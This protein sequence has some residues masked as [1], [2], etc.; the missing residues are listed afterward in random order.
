MASSRA[1]DLLKRVL[2][3]VFGG[4]TFWGASP[5]PAFGAHF[6]SAPQSVSPVAPGVPAHAPSEVGVQLGQRREPPESPR[7]REAALEAW[8]AQKRNATRGSSSCFCWVSLHCKGFGRSSS[9]FFSHSGPPGRSG[10]R[11]S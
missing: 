7:E 3:G 9:H 8:R 10:C 6:S 11:T 1:S 5:P 4:R 2:G